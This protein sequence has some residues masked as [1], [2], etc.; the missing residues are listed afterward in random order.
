MPVYYYTYNPVAKESFSHIYYD[1]YLA[2]II[3]TSKLMALNDK[4]G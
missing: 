1:P 3:S 4:Y 2:F